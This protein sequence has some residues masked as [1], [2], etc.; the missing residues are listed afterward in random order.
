MH[1]IL[2]Q[3][4]CPLRGKHK[5]FSTMYFANTSHQHFQFV[6]I[7]WYVLILFSFKILMFLKYK[8][9]QLSREI[10]PQKQTKHQK[11]VSTRSQEWDKSDKDKMLLVFQGEY[12]L[13]G[14]ARRGWES[15]AQRMEMHLESNTLYAAGA[16]SER[17][18]FFNRPGL[19]FPIGLGKPASSLPSLKSTPTGNRKRPWLFP[20]HI[21]FHT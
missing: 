3:I 17:P 9:F 5:G 2:S 13:L 18:G 16:E 11:Q 8:P 15:Q 14:K 12:G 19:L 1:N 21:S 6:S 20:V 7:Y 10:G 4:K